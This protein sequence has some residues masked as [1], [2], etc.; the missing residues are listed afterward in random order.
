[1]SFVPL[2]AGPLFSLT[3]FADVAF[4]SFCLGTFCSCSVFFSLTWTSLSLGLVYPLSRTFLS[5]ALVLPF[6]ADVE[7][8]RVFCSKYFV[9]LA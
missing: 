8:A 7:F 5:S 4:A 9:D 6:F 3:S 2:R 1:M